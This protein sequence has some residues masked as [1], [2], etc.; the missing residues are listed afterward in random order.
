MVDFEAPIKYII[1]LCLF[2]MTREAI[3]L[4]VL[5]DPGHG[6]EEYGAVSTLG[7]KKITEKELTL[8][9]SLLLK[10]ELDDYATVYLSRSVDRTVTLQ[11]RA[12]IAEKIKADLVLSIHL[13]AS[14][15]KEAHGF[16]VYYLNNSNESAV[17]KVESVENVNVK[18]EELVIN[19]ILIDLVIQKTITQSKVLGQYVLKDVSTLLKQEG[20][21][22]RGLKAGM[23]YILA[24]CKRPGLLLEAGFMSNPK[25]LKKLIDPKFQHQLMKAVAQGVRKYAVTKK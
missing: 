8:Q 16:E 4:T 19:Q 13:N 21:S 14:P 22:N 7:T 24:L 25:E 11:E 18:G 5:I 20:I 6:G 9:M 23:F 2:F 15:E 3:S 1:L 10:K 12:D 17:R